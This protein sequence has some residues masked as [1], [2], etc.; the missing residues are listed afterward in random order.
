MDGALRVQH[1]NQA[2]IVWFDSGW[3]IPAC[4]KE[5]Q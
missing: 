5:R 1:Y 3:R 2:I 4:K